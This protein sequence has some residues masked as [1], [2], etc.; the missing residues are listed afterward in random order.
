MATNVPNNHRRNKKCRCEKCTKLRED[1]NGGC[2]HPNKC[3]ERAKKL[4]GTINEKW[5]PTS[6]HPPEFFTH[7]T[8]EEVG[9]RYDPVAK[10]TIHTLNPFRVEETL[11]NCFRVFTGASQPLC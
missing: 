2:K 3:I 10:E 1:T 5:N 9:S 11:A 7:P 6:T 4:L 8:P